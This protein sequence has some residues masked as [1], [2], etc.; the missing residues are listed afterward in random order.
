MKYFFAGMVCSAVISLLV[1]F[2]PGTYRSMGKEAKEQCE[3]S[4]PR[5]QRCVITAVPEVKK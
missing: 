1:I 2:A 5:D 4:L 3:K